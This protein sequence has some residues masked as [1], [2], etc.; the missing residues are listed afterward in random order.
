[1]HD[2]EQVVRGALAVGVRGF[3]LKSDAGRDLVSAVESLQHHGTFFSS[4]V[5]AFV[6]QRYLDQTH[7]MGVEVGSGNRLTP[8]EIQVLKLLAEG[9]TSKGAG[10]ALN[11]RTGTVDTHR[12][13]I[14]RKLNLHSLAE[15]TLYAVRN[16]IVQVS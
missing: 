14:M 5:A 8:R 12:N 15:L 9:K 13:N 6:P 16:G 10:L 7:S 11:L 3:L 4:Q 1:V 2:S